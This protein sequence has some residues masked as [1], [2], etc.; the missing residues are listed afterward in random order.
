MGLKEIPVS[1]GNVW[2][3]KEAYYYEN[4]WSGKETYYWQS[5]KAA[6]S[7]LEP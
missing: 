7:R 2:S 4:V 1:H 6:E 3:G 5:K